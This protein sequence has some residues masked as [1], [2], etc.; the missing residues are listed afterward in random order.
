LPSAICL[1][2]GQRSKEDAAFGRK[3]LPQSS[4]RIFTEVTEINLG[5]ERQSL[6]ELHIGFFCVISDFSEQ[7]LI[8]FGKKTLPES[9]QEFF[10]RE[11]K[12]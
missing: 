3:T 9:L 2:T 8:A 12:S 1:T 11:Y 7:Y 10:H 6:S 4:K 5:S